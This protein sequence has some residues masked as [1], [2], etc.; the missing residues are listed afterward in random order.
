M[1]NEESQQ[2]GKEAFE[3]GEPKTTCPFYKTLEYE[4]VEYWLLGWEIAEVQRQVRMKNEHSA[5][6]Q[7][8]LS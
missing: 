6:K 2:A 3:N 8:R 1:L 4:S 5:I 7:S